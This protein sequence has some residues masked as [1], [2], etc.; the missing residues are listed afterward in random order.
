MQELQWDLG[1]GKKKNRFTGFLLGFS[2]ASSAADCV[3]IASATKR[4]NRKRKKKPTSTSWARLFQCR[5]RP[6]ARGVCVCVDS[7]KGQPRRRKKKKKKP[8]PVVGQWKSDPEIIN[9]VKLGKNS[10][11]ERRKV[12]FSDQ[13]SDNSIGR[14]CRSHESLHLLFDKTS[15]ENWNS[16]IGKYFASSDPQNTISDSIDIRW[17]NAI[18]N[19]RSEVIESP[20]EML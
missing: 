5:R 11:K 15:F 20:Y 7:A 1:C 16:F 14:D 19:I 8:R 6:E 18:H 12:Q 13:P 10:R 9:P 4:K 3:A 2:L 17:K